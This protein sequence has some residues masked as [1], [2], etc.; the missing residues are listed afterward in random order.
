MPNQMFSYK[1]F[2]KNN[3]KNPASINLGITSYVWKLS[4]IALLLVQCACQHSLP[5]SDINNACALFNEKFDWYRYHHKARREHGIPIWLQLSFVHMESRFNPTA[6]PIKEMKN[7]V[8]TKTLSSALGYAQALNGSWAEYTSARPSWKRSRTYYSD[9]IDF[10]GWYLHRCHL[11]AG[12]AKNDPYN[13]YLCYHEGISGYKKGSYKQK[14]AIIAYAKKTD[15]LARKYYKQLQQCES[16]L[17]WR[18][19][20]FL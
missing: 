1:S 18:H 13:M 9:S 16:S 10:M 11:K 15:L 2:S 7:G 14:K 4:I 20:Y 5:T 6:V 8:V 12:V 19:A 3:H 17:R